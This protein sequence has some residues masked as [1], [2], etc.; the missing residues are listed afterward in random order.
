[1]MGRRGRWGDDE[2]KVEGIATIDCTAFCTQDLE[3]K[4]DL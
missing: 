1:M 2:E 4:I 3:K